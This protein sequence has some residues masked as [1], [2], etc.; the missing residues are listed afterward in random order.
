[1]GLLKYKIS[2][3]VIFVFLLLLVNSQVF[4][5]LTTHTSHLF[6]IFVLSEYKLKIVF[7]IYVNLISYLFAKLYLT[8][9]IESIYLINFY[10]LIF[11]FMLIYLIS[12]FQN[13]DIFDVV[14]FYLANV[15]FF[16]FPIII[17]IHFYFSKKQ[18]ILNANNSNKFIL[19]AFN[20]FSIGIIFYIIKKYYN[21]NKIID[22]HLIQFIITF[23][24][25][26]LPLINLYL[27][28]LIE[29]NHKKFNMKIFFIILVI[30]LLTLV[31]VS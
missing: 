30:L 25:F 2:N 22:Y 8:R 14:V 9:Q 15:L 4:S 28:L 1:V 17:F 19:L 21:L 12:L 29:H 10:I 11:I 26:T 23:L 7:F 13:N 3:I 27:S 6:Y 5:N 31:I 16:L 18:N 20:G 24:C